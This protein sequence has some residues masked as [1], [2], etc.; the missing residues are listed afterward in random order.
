ME[1]PQKNIKLTR[2]GKPDKRVQ[3]GAKNIKIALE[4]RKE[5]FDEYNRKKKMEKGEFQ[6]S[7]S[8]SEESE[9]EESESEEEIFITKK[10][11]EVQPPK[12]I[13]KS[14]NDDMI[15]E[16]LEKLESMITF[17]AKE[18]SNK[19]KKIKKKPVEKKTIIQIQQPQQQKQ[20]PRVESDLERKLKGRLLNF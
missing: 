11:K 12:E 15:N 1:E 13:K 6:F 18:K 19:K 16:K 14:K 9:S 4:K 20:E 7:E 8:E 3:T 17:M 10:K 5:I 2:K